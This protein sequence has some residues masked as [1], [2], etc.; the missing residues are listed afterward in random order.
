MFD[1]AFTE[2][3]IISV[4]ALIVIGPER[5][6]TVAR[7]LGHLLGR[8]R[9][10][11]SSVKID[12]HNEMR[13]D[14]LK[15]LHASVKEAADS[16]ENSVRQEVDEIKSMTGAE[17]LTTA[18]SPSSTGVKAEIESKTDLSISSAQPASQQ[19]ISES[20]EQKRSTFEKDNK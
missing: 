8:V 10:Y 11:I 14:E 9:R 13:M 18:S 3:L 20:N 15:N 2:I 19:Q 7:T 16:M 4:V 12:I 1:I 5:L 17:N 6:P